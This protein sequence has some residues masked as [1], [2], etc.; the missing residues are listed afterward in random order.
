MKVFSRLLSLRV[1]ALL[2]LMGL[3]RAGYAQHIEVFDA[4]GATETYPN[5]VNEFGR[6]TGYHEDASRHLHGFVRSPF[7]TISV[8]DAPPFGDSTVGVGVGTVPLAINATG[9]IVGTVW[10][11]VSGVLGARGFVRDERGMIAEFEAAP[12][13]VRTDVQA[14][15]V[16]GWAAGIYREAS[17][18]A[19]G[20]V[21][22][23][24]GTLST[25]DAPG[26]LTFI[27]EIRPNGDV[28]GVYQQSS[29]LFH[30]FV[31]ELSGSFSTFDAPDVDPGVGGVFCGHCAGTFTTAATP[32]GR[33]VGY[34][35]A[36]GGLIR[37]FLRT[38][39]GAFSNLDVPGA[40]GTRPEAINI[41]GAVAGEY[42][43]SGPF[44]QHG[45]LLPRHG[46]LESFDLPDAS[47]LVVTGIDLQNKVIGYFADASGT[48]GFIRRPRA[49]C[50]H[51]HF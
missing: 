29:G 46:S 24:Y 17:S 35:G 21:R 1:S 18:L 39:D 28:I 13:A 6:I 32:T 4:P 43:N 15:N 37:A 48:H 11:V 8:F 30:G 51:F 19:H 33:I 50:N 27:R 22:S 14:I 20:F 47:R 49:G 2:A 42:V 5:A 23:P 41:E 3:S 10:G 12:G 7:G 26:F 25:F 38:P 16:F 40:I 36:T 45:F 34:Y 31:R 9:Q 44:A